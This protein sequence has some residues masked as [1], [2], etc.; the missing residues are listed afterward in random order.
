M[1][2]LFLLIPIKPSRSEKNGKD[3]NKETHLKMQ[4]LLPKVSRPKYKCEWKLP[5]IGHLQ[6]SDLIPTLNMAQWHARAQD[7]EPQDPR[8]KAIHSY[9]VHGER[10]T[11]RL[12]KTVFKIVIQI[13][14]EQTVISNI[15]YFSFTVKRIGLIFLLG[16]P[17]KKG[18]SASFLPY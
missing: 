11:K 3:I 1:V 12:Q 5:Q 2:P 18:Q 9:I 13:L 10:P 4:K 7:V 14:K 6:T 16:K 15:N 17:T 8:F